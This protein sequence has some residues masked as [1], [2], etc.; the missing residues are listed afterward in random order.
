M[1]P[2]LA[3]IGVGKGRGSF[4]PRIPIPLILLWPLVGA[5]YVGVRIARSCCRAGD[6]AA[7]LAIAQSAIALLGDLSGLRIDVHSAGGESVYIRLF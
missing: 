3:V 2:A 5:L 7:Q 4:R 6:R 1:I